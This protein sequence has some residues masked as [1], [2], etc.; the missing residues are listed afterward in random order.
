MTTATDRIGQ[1]I[2]EHCYVVFPHSRSMVGV[3]VVIRIT[4]KMAVI[5]NL[6]N[7]GTKEVI[8]G[9]KEV[10]V[11]PISEATMYALTRPNRQ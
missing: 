5:R 6:D 8:K 3:G 11:L 4:P 9:Q 7:F 1:E 2:T 10:V